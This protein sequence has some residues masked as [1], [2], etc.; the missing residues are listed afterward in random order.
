MSEAMER[1]REVLQSAMHPTLQHDGTQG[2][3]PKPS[4][5]RGDITIP[6]ALCPTD[7]TTTRPPVVT[8]R[9]KRNLGNQ[10]YRKTFKS[11]KPHRQRRRTKEKPSTKD[12]ANLLIMSLNVNGV[13]TSQKTRALSAYIASLPRQPDASILVETH[14]MEAETEK[15]HLPTYHKG[16]SHCRGDEA[17]RSCGGVLIVVKNTV[18]YTKV[19]DLPGVELPLNSCSIWL[20]LNKPEL[21]KVRP[22]GAYFTPAAKPKLEQVEMLTDSRSMHRYNGVQTGHLIARDF[23]HPNWQTQYETWAGQYGIWELTNPR[24]R[25]FISGNS[26]DEILFVPGDVIPA[27]FLLC[28]AID[29]EERTEEAYYPSSTGDV[30]VVGNHYPVFLTLHNEAPPPPAPLRRLYID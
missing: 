19:T 3:P 11:K 1:T 24:K 12:E 20:Y 4:Q 13:R 28:G 10:K 18:T 16:H 17:E 30:E 2:Q 23:N 21:P 8:V 25:T 14:L 6:T 7:H 26:L 5:G 29:T 22:T 15:F 27:E 9:R